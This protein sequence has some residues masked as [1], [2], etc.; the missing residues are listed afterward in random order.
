MLLYSYIYSVFAIMMVIHSLDNCSSPWV[1]STD[2]VVRTHITSYP[3]MGIQWLRR[4][5]TLY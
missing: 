5:V 3:F 1:D 4:T 2:F